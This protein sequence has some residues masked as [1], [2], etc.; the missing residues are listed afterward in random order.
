M[1]G[2]SK[3]QGYT[4]KQVGSLSC[5]KDF[6][7]SLKQVRSLCGSLSNVSSVIVFNT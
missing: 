3:M 1:A 6:T 5:L 4:V 2:G 7:V